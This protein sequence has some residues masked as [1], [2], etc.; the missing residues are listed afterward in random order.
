[1]QLKNKQSLTKI[2]EGLQADVQMKKYQIYELPYKD[3]YYAIKIFKETTTQD[4]RIG[5]IQAS[6]KIKS[7]YIIVYVCHDEEKFE[8]ILYE[9]FGDYNLQQYLQHFKLEQ[10]HVNYIFTQIIEGY[11]DI[12]QSGYY[13]CDLKTANVLVDSSTLQIKICD[14]GFANQIQQKIKSRRGSRGYFAPEF[15]LDGANFLNEKTE[16][17]AMGVIL[18]QLLTNE[19]PYNNQNNCQKW[20]QI[21]KS[22]WKDFWKNKRIPQQYKEIIQNVFEMDPNKRCNINY[23]Q[24]IFHF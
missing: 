6:Q 24:N 15:F 20:I 11:Y 14:L 8:W 5:E 3:L 4:E 21:T 1:M 16:V 13:H 7:K 9:K 2:D 23:L 22:N 10:Y 18:Y 17:F 19:F 12:L